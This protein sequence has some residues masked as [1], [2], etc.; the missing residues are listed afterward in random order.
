VD[1]EHELPR[2]KLTL[3]DQ[4]WKCRVEVNGQTIPVSRLTLVMDGRDGVA[5]TLECRPALMETV[6]VTGA[7]QVDAQD[8]ADLARAAEWREMPRVE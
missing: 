3:G 1:S 6:T 4:P 8:A 7:F 2:V 5:L